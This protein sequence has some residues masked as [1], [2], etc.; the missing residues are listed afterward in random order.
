MGGVAGLLVRVE[1]GPSQAYAPPGGTARQV[2]SGA[3][4]CLLA[5][6]VS[7]PLLVQVC[8]NAGFQR[9]VKDLDPVLNCSDDLVLPRVEGVLQRC[10]PLELD[11]GAEELPEWPAP[12]NGAGSLRV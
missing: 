8:A 10:G 11:L 1:P 12:A 7:H 4:A 3:S 9:W 5:H 6:E 2:G